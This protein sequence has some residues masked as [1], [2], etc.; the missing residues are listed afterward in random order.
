M[1]ITRHETI[2]VIKDS[3]VKEGFFR[4]YTTKL[5]NFKK[6]CK[7]IGGEQNL[8][9]VETTSTKREISSWDCR[10]PRAYLSKATWGVAKERTGARPKGNVGVLEAWRSNQ[11]TKEG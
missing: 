11:K 6:L 7:R 4:F 2:I 3:D 10:V 5:S 9:S 1:V 8:I